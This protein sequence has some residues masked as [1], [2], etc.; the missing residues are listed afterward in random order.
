MEFRTSRLHHQ[1]GVLAQHI[2]KTTFVF[3]FPLN[4]T[5]IARVFKF[6]AT[7]VSD[8]V[9]NSPPALYKPAHNDA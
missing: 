4:F 8:E 6:F 2:E 7:V 1:S 3:L 9:L 5:E